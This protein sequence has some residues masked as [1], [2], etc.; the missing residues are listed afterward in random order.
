MSAIISNPD[1]RLRHLLLAAAA[2]CVLVG[3]AGGGG[4]SSPQPTQ[5]VPPQPPP[6]PT[7]GLP[8]PAAAPSGPDYLPAGRDWQLVW[9]DEF[10]GTELDRAKWT[11]EE[12]CWGGGNNERQCY[13][14]REDN[15]QIVNGL[16]RLIGQS[17]TF[18]GPEFPPE[19]N[20]SSMATQEYTSGKVRTRDLADWT[21]GRV[22]ARMK[23]PAGQGTWP[24]FWM[25]PAESIYGSW[26]LSG[27]IDIMEA[28]NLGANCSDCT[29]AFE[30]RVLG[31][32]HFGNEIPDNEYFGQRTTLPNGALPQDE[33]HVYSVE[34]G[35]GKILWFVDDQLYHKADTGDW[36]T[37]APNAAGNPNAPFDQ[38]FYLMC[39][40]AVGGNFPE[41]TNEST[42]D[43][44][45]FPNEFLV[46]WVRVYECATDA[47]TGRT[48]MQ[49]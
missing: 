28:V 8:T 27:E 2:G 36:Y 24:A 35:E 10:E 32:I 16:L 25:M 42:F 39:N 34:W 44:D 20:S 9:S 7:S 29:G 37:G 31:T 11:P 5:Q 18:T 45:S 1:T 19:V 17:E 23:L 48:C 46:D 41:T 30:D 26:P 49:E 22:S 4:S 15:V 6:P 3:C 14:D 47:A 40:L 13:T 21:Y 38:R 33:Y 12:S 43:P